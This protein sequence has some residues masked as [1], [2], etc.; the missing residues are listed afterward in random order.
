MNN[1]ESRTDSD[2]SNK[3]YNINNINNNKNRNNIVN[4]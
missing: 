1:I 3:G 2:G 4:K